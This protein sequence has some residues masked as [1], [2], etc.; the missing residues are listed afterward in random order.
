LQDQR[1]F[2]TQSVRRLFTALRHRLV[3]GD[4]FAAGSSACN[5]ARETVFPTEVSVPV[6]KKR[7][8]ITN[9]TVML[10]K[11]GREIINC[12]KSLRDAA[13]GQLEIAQFLV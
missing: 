7:L 4:A 13:G 6:I 8:N 12:G 1:I 3:P 11:Y 2:V 10:M 5:S 9:P